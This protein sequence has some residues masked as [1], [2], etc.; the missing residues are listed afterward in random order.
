LRPQS[1][2][3]SSDYHENLSKAVAPGAIDDP[4]PANEEA[5]AAI[6]LQ[7]ITSIFFADEKISNYVAYAVFGALLVAWAVAVTRLNPDTNNYWLAIGTLTVLTLLPIYHRAYDSRF[8]LLSIPAA[9][10]VFE[11]KRIVGT[12]A[13]ILI[14]LSTVSV[15]HWAQ[16]ILLRHG[17]L[18]SVQQ[19][20]L[21]FI[22]LLRES[23]LRLLL[24][25]GLFLF[26]LF[27]G[28]AAECSATDVVRADR[29]LETLR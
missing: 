29:T 11:K 9:V 7:T 25:S 3:W 23:D 13:S 6:N 20:K 22:L 28:H 27:E 16:V 10:I 19:S 1:A 4:R 2:N 17:L 21:L 18:Q 5:V 15:Q 8:L 12:L 14:G 24:L 26:A